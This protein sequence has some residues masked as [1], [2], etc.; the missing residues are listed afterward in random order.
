MLL[1]VSKMW[2][3]RIGLL[4]AVLPKVRQP[5]L[6][7]ATTVQDVR[8]MCG[9]VTEAAGRILRAQNWC[10]G[11]QLLRNLSA[12]KVPQQLMVQWC[13]RMCM[14]HRERERRKRV[15][16]PPSCLHRFPF[17]HFFFRSDS[18]AYPGWGHM[19]T[20]SESKCA[21]FDAPCLAG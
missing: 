13:M 7:L 14:A 19:G 11:T 17:L 18:C 20:H 16:P 1:M 10:Q 15:L 4:A 2:V 12:T 5:V 3:V 6:R 9:S 21:S 8:I